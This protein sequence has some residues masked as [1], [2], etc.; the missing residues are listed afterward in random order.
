[1]A[2]TLKS[3]LAAEKL[4][5]M[6][7]WRFIL[8]TLSD[9]MTVAGLDFMILAAETCGTDCWWSRCGGATYAAAKV[10]DVLL[11]EFVAFMENAEASFAADDTIINNK[12][13]KPETF[14]AFLVGARLNS[15]KCVPE[16]STWDAH[17][18]GQMVLAKEKLLSP[19]RCNRAVME[20]IRWVVLDRH[21]PQ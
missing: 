18:V 5:V 8:L 13:T 4:T 19:D 12:Q 10:L 1:M 3:F 15:L 7:E 11:T 20:C 9:H 16:S 14:N 2:Q 21:R 17:L 6:E